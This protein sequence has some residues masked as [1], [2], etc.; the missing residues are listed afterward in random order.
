M[1]RTIEKSTPSV[2][3]T[4]QG[5]NIHDINKELSE[6]RQGKTR[7]EVLFRCFLNH[8]SSVSSTD[9]SERLK[10]EVS[11]SIYILK[12]LEKK[13]LIELVNPNRKRN[14]R[15]QI[16]SMG[17]QVMSFILHSLFFSSVESF[18][19]SLGY[20]RIEDGLLFVKIPT[21][22][23]DFLFVNK[24]IIIVRAVDMV[25]FDKE[26]VSHFSHVLEHNN[27]RDID[28]ERGVIITYNP[29]KQSVINEARKKNI[30][31][32]D[33]KKIDRFNGRFLF[34]RKQKQD[35]QNLKQSISRGCRMEKKDENKINF[36]HSKY[37]SG[38]SH[39]V[40]GTVPTPES[41][42]DKLKERI[43]YLETKVS[44]LEEALKN[45]EDE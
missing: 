12:D 8:N 10:I 4:L 23:K 14:K 31:I 20:K 39:F 35:N 7:Q 21:M 41:E 45:N 19:K 16:T 11:Q 2:E 28:I 22:Y 25:S 33:N 40:Y 30:D 32:W 29:V 38:K 3:H 34:P 44:R 1:N 17:R 9:I 37:G 15:Y 43:K 18:F 42:I 24:D 36:I 27:N 13:K 26:L 5:Y 6:M